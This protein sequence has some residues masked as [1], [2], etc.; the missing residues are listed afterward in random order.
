M[1]YKVR[2]SSLIIVHQKPNIEHE[3]TQLKPSNPFADSSSRKL[4]SLLALF[5]ETFKWLCKRF[6]VKVRMN[7]S[8][9]PLLRDL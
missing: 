8:L 3:M 6:L 2:P 9:G 5:D 1:N 7:L 4:G